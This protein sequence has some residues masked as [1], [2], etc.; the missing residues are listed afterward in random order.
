MTHVFFFAFGGS[1]TQAKTATSNKF[2]SPFWN[3]KKASKQQ[4]AKVSTYIVNY[5]IKHNFSKDN[6]IC[7]VFSWQGLKTA[8]T[9][10]LSANV[11]Y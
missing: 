6:T 7:Q 9:N 8:S 4:S 1:S 10:E 3:K 2:F 11:T 5:I